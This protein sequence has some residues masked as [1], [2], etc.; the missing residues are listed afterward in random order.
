MTQSTISP[1]ESRY[2]IARG[3]NSRGEEIALTF[4]R[5]NRWHNLSYIAALLGLM[6]T[7]GPARLM[8]AHSPA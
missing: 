4:D 8:L 2:I 6:K 5:L 7:N 1:A 3:L